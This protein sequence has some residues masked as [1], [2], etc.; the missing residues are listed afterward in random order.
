VLTYHV[1]N[2][3]WTQPTDEVCYRWLPDDATYRAGEPWPSNGRFGNG[4][5][6]VLYTALT[7]AAAASEFLRRH[8]EFLNL[9]DA[10]R[11][12]IWEFDV[13]AS[14]PVLDVRTE[15]NAELIA[16][17]F[18]RL[19][20]SDADEAVR[21]AECRVLASD[22]EQAGTGLEYPSPAL[23]GGECFVLFGVRGSAWETS[24]EREVPRPGVDPTL[25]AVLPPKS[26][27]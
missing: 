20:S 4:V 7:P 1:A 27:V 10:S 18:D 13:K 12:R 14:A 5:R 17:P 22:V 25:V 8:P 19:T 11:I 24:K 15:P 26:P 23:P 9:Q 3:V 2:G 6:R 21:Y 16:F